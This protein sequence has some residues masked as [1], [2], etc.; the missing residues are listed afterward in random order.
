MIPDVLLDIRE[1]CARADGVVQGLAGGSQS[2]VDLSGRLCGLD[3]GS[4]VG[5][6]LV[7]RFPF[8]W[9]VRPSPFCWS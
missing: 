5:K 8:A 7:I 9:P 3:G 1:R 4:G 6:R 2:G